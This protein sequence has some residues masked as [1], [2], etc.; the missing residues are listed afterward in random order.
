MKQLPYSAFGWLIFFFHPLLLLAQFSVKPEDA[1]L[2]EKLYDQF[3]EEKF[4]ALLSDEHYGFEFDPKAQHAI[5]AKQTLTERVVSLKYQNIFEK[6]IFYD[7]TTQIAN[8]KA[9]NARNK[10]SYINPVYTNYQSAGIFHDDVKVCYFQ[11]SI[12]SKGEQFAY[13]YEKKYS[14]IKYLTRIF[15]HESYPILEKKITFE[16]PDWLKLDL[17]EIN[18]EHYTILKNETKEKDKRIITYTIQSMPAYRREYRAPALAKSYPHLLILCR[19]YQKDGST[20][21][22]FSS[23]DD[24]Y[25]WYASLCK[26]VDNKIEILKPLV[27]KLVASKNTD[28]EKVEAIFYWVQEN[29]RYIAFENGIMGFKPEAA[30]TVFEKR[31]GD[32][33]GMANLTKE[34]LKIAGYDAHLTWIGTR[35]IPYDYSIPSLAVDNHMICTLMLNGKKFFLDPTETFISLD[36]YAHRIQG[37]PV[38]IENGKQYILDRVPE[39]GKERN[40]VKSKTTLKI[41]EDKLTGNHQVMYHGEEKTQMLRSYQAIRSDNKEEALQNFV[42]KGDKNLSVRN[43]N[44]SD[45]TERSQPLNISYDFNWENRLLK[46]GHELYVNIDKDKEFSQLVF[47]NRHQDYE[48]PHKIMMHHETVLDIPASYKVEYLPAEVTA[49]NDHFSFHIS[50]RKVNNAIHYVKKISIEE[51]IIKKEDFE[52]WNAMIEKA[53]EIYNDQIILIKTSK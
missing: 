5:S 33:K 2:A 37:R 9:F 19:S 32:C 17:L 3:P 50:Y 48:F 27:Q 46:V 16:V 20:T 38:M 45:F 21:N 49:E 13:T 47:K 18:F 22:L 36:D 34:M 40:L 8:L 24:L 11:K 53:H 23:T 44:T 12:E 7:E 43:L 28:E 1:A 31:Y 42:T 51:G 26:E 4:V 10:T 15:F 30:H 52:Q 29:I 6:G 35:D 39:F 25:G 14:D 41:Q